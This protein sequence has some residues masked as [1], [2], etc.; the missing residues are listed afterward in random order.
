LVARR[1]PGDFPDNAIDTVLP[2]EYWALHM[3]GV[4]LD[5]SPCLVSQFKQ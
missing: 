3:N 4:S 1:S 2:D 5:P